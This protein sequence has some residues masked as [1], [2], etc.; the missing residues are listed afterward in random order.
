MS[1]PSQSTECPQYKGIKDKS[2]RI[3]STHR[4]TTVRRIFHVGVTRDANQHTMIQ[5]YQRTAGISFA[6][7]LTQRGFHLAYAAQ[8]MGKPLRVYIRLPGGVDTLVPSKTAISRW[9][10]F[11]V[12][13]SG[14]VRNVVSNKSASLYSRIYYMLRYKY[15]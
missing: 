5:G 3:K 1:V 12:Y 14:I 2:H 9:E 11:G 8:Q 13:A 4:L 15:F 7:I 10:F 6:W